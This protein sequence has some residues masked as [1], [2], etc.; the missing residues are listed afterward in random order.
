MSI[1]NIALEV[2]V[3][4]AIE[5][6]LKTG[7]KNIIHLDFHYTSLPGSARI[8][9]RHPKNSEIAKT[10]IELDREQAGSLVVKLC[11]RFNIQHY[12]LSAL[13]FELRACELP[14]FWV[15]LAP[16]VNDELTLNKTKSRMSPVT[17]D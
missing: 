17:I 4:D 10:I 2:D 6:E 16:Y 14:C 13:N 3:W 9:I 12:N 7:L 5:D 15:Q 1:R 11:E 8:I